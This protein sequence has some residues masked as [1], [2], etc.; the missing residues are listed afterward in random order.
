MTALSRCRVVDAALHVSQ[1]W[2]VNRA[3]EILPRWQQARWECMSV[4]NQAPF[5]GTPFSHKQFNLRKN[6]SNGP[7][8]TCINMYTS[9]T[10]NVPSAYEALGT[11][12]HASA[13]TPCSERALPC[14][15]D[16][17]S[18]VA[19]NWFYAEK[20][21]KANLVV[22]RKKTCTGWTSGRP[23]T[24]IYF[25]RFY[26]C[27]RI[28]QTTNRTDECIPTQRSVRHSF[29][30]TADTRSSPFTRSTPIELCIHSFTRRGCCLRGGWE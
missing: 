4:N 19:A 5:F 11:F 6:A 25:C 2:I 21:K 18:S 9:H 1:L 27:S 22:I 24:I 14:V 10:T 23:P 3:G 20:E 7:E 29:T 13:C 15:L 28:I 26:Q 17:L 30:R 16:P 8:R 12:E